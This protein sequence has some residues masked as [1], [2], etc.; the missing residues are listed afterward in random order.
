ME[1]KAD[2]KLDFLLN[3]MCIIGAFIFIS[4]ALMV[5]IL[6]INVIILTF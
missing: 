3:C 1:S 6:L 5:F 4:Y 2:K